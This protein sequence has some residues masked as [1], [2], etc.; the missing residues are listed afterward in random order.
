MLIPELDGKTFL[1]ASHPMTI[2]ILSSE[3]TKKP[4]WV[5]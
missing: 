3:T 2:M 4:K 5:L 1:I